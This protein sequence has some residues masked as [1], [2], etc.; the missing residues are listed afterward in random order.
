M[1]SRN[2]LALVMAI[3]VVMAMAAGPALA[4][5]GDKG[6]PDRDP[7]GGHTCEEQAPPGPVVTWADDSHFSFTLDR[8]NGSACVDVLAPAGPWQVTVEGSGARSLTLVPGDSYSPGDS[9]GGASLHA[10]SIYGTLTL[11]LPIDTRTKIPAATVNA[12]GVAFGEWIGEV[13]VMEQTGDP[14]PLVF[15][16]FLTGGNKATA[17]IHVDLP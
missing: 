3:S 17:T 5:K 4:K 7:V 8:D 14:N 9:C 11:P 16:A 2:R 13:L 12:C 1:K 6:P 15:Q 10:G